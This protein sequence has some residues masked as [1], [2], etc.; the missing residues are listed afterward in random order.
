MSLKRFSVINFANV[1]FQ[2]CKFLT[3]FAGCQFS[4]VVT[5]SSWWT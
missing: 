4:I 2:F 5:H 3:Y 1:I